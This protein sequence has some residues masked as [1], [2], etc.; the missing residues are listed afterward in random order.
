MLFSFLDWPA[1][2]RMTDVEVEFIY[3]C[4]YIL[5]NF[6]IALSDTTGRQMTEWHLK[7]MLVYLH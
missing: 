3:L 4:T 6:Y 2:D 7:I 5:Y 1:D